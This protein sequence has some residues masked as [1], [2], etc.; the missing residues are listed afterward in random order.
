[1]NEKEIKVLRTIEEEAMRITKKNGYVPYQITISD[2]QYQIYKKIMRQ[3]KRATIMFQ[4]VKWS[5]N[6][7]CCSIIIASLDQ[8]WGREL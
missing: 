8:S 4:G 2:R 3:G 1:M 7:Q 5:L 6:V